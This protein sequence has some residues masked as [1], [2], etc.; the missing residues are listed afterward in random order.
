MKKRKSGAPL[1]FP[2]L[3]G[4]PTRDRIIIL[5]SRLG[6]SQAA[7]G[8]LIGLAERAVGSWENGTNK[9]SGPALRL[10]EQLEDGLG[11]QADPRPDRQQKHRSLTE[12]LKKA[13]ST[14]TKQEA[15]FDW[16]ANWKHEQEA[17][18][19]RIKWALE[20]RERGLFDRGLEELEAV[21]AK[22][23]GALPRV[24]ALLLEA[25]ED[26]EPTTKP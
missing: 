14:P 1:R 19:A 18:I 24:I 21:T 22:R 2:P 20:T 13:K 26:E 7:L 11:N 16:A 23:F 4:D 6:L 25:V 3:T 17:I 9:P 5:R 8:E 15:A 10:L 12:R